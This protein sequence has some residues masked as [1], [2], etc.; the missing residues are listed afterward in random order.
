MGSDVWIIDV[1][2]QILIVFRSKSGFS[3][4]SSCSESLLVRFHFEYIFI[5]LWPSKSSFDSHPPS[6]NR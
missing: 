2:E 5:P 1:S 4:F 6:K 3:S